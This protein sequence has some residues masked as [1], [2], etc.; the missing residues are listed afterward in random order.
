MADE[1]KKRYVDQK[2]LEHIIAQIVSKLKGGTN[3]NAEIV[4][5]LGQLMEYKRMMDKT[6]NK[7]IEVL[8]RE[9]Q[10]LKKAVGILSKKKDGSTTPS[11][12]QEPSNPPS[13]GNDNDDCSCMDDWEALTPEEID[14]IIN[15]ILNEG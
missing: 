13:G 11:Q 8:A 10:K 3:N 5:I 1:N 4:L 6:Q 15:S 9:I 12:P 2:G 14:E 7:R